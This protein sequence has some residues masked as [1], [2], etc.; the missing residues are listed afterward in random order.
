[1]KLARY[2]A[3]SGL[4]SRRAAERMIR[5]GR[6][7]VNGGTVTNVAE[8]V[9]PAVDRVLVDREEVV[10]PSEFTYVM[11]NKP[12]GYVC[13]TV[14]RGGGRSIYDILPEQYANLK[15]TG[16][17]DAGSEG[18]LLLTNDGELI[19]RYTHPRFKQTKYYLVKTRGVP[20]RSSIRGLERGI[21]LD[22]G[23]TLPCSVKLWKKGDGWAWYRVELREGRKR[24]LRRMFEAVG[25]EVE[26]LRRVG[27]GP[28]RLG[29]VPAGGVRVLSPDEVHMLKESVGLC[30][31]NR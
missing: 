31:D 22:D 20:E 1:M 8:R 3:L 5:D 9:R 15:Y 23:M 10:L 7:E 26:R 27:I 21:E 19:H 18:A 16:R 29:K 11:F 6:V 14:S 12:P 30:K 28:V 25:H 13:S 2:I 4:C 17:L 24:Q